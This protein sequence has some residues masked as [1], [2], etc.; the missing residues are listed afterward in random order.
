MC[1]VFI[2]PTD[3]MSPLSH[4]RFHRYGA[5]L[6]RMLLYTGCHAYSW[7]IMKCSAR[8]MCEVDGTAHTRCGWY[9]IQWFK[10]QTSSVDMNLF[11]WTRRSHC[12]FHWDPEEICFIFIMSDSYWME[13]GIHFWSEWFYWSLL[14]SLA[15]P[16][17]QHCFS[18]NKSSNITSILHLTVIQSS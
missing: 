9:N 18:S 14:F 1:S 12:W 11:M 3:F 4:E 13:D 7:W 15:P 8:W 2:S 16:S 17:N 5:C 6:M 10:V